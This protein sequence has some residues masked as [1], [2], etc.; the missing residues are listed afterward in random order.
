MDTS[1]WPASQQGQISEDLL[2]QT[3]QC[4]RKYGKA[5]VTFLMKKLKKHHK[6]L[7]PVL[8]RLERKGI[9][10]SKGVHKPKWHLKEE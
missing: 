3:L 1:I 2:N 7:D 6:E 9:I 8:K 5:N 4:I 10:Y